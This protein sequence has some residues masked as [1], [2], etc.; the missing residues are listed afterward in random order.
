MKKVTLLLLAVAFSLAGIAQT[1]Y[2]MDYDG[3]DELQANQNAQTYHRYIW[4]L[5]TTSDPVFGNSRWAIVDFD[6]LIVSED[7]GNTFTQLPTNGDY[8]IVLDSVYVFY[9]YQSNGGSNL[10]NFNV[11]NYDDVTRNSIGVP[12]EIPNPVA[13]VSPVFS[14]T[15]TEADLVSNTSV[16]IMKFFPNATFSNGDYFSIY[17]TN[18]SDTLDQF[19]FLAGYKEDCADAELG[20]TSSVTLNTTTYTYLGAVNG[21]LTPNLYTFGSG[22]S[23][24]NYLIQN[25]VMVPFVT[26]TSNTFVAEAVSN[27]LTIETC[28]GTTFELSSAVAGGVGPFQYSWSPAEGLSDST[29]ANPIVTVGNNN[30]QYTLTVTD[31]GNNDSTATDN[32]NVISWPVTVNAGQDV[33]IGCSE[34]TNINAFASAS[35]Q[36]VTIVSTT[37]SGGNSNPLQVSAPGQYVVTATNSVGCSAKDTVV[38][39]VSG[40]NDVDFDLPSSI[41]LNQSSTFTNESGN[42]SGWSFAWAIDGDTTYSVDLVKTFTEAGNKT[43][44][45]IADSAECFGSTS[46]TFTVQTCSGIEEALQGELADVFPNPSNGE[47]SLDL[48]SVN[49]NNI[50]VRVVDLTGKTISRTDKV[51]GNS[52]FKLDISEAAEGVYLLQVITDESTLIN[53]LQVTK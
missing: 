25:I 4:T 45:L 33:S 30:Q 51:A 46:K 35:G 16:N 38:V 49:S 9:N 14:A 12:E 28:P 37:W 19:S 52:V 13:A 42:T 36:G 44:Y 18:Q 24:P 7:G 53:K 23:C 43:L 11:Y 41:C 47:F 31:L 2:I 3:Y 50:T 21:F 15:K 40:Y 10:I 17:M 6:Q 32:V 48:R 1:Q 29:V 8:T 34:S 27:Q 22:L 39:T 20:L 5:N 26:I